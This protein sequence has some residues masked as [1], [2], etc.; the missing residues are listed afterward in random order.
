M[1]V[2]SKQDHKRQSLKDKKILFKT[3]SKGGQDHCNRRT[4]G[5]QLDWKKR[6]I[7]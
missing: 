4:A 2:P 5:T 3:I 6:E 7:F 1:C